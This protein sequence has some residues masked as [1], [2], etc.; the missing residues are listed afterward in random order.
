[1]PRSTSVWRTSVPQK[2][3]E[4][5]PMEVSASKSP[6]HRQL[7][8]SR[9]D[10]PSLKL[11]PQLL[12]D[13]V[14]VHQHYRVR[15]ASDKGLGRHDRLASSRKIPALLERSMST[16]R[17]TTSRSCNMYRKPTALAPA[18]QGGHGPA[19]PPP[20]VE[21][22]PP[23][24]PV[25][26][27]GSVKCCDLCPASLV[28][29]PCCGPASPLPVGSARASMERNCRPSRSPRRAAPGSRI[30]RRSVSATAGPEVG[31]MLVDD[32][33]DRALADDEVEIFGTKSRNRRRRARGPR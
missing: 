29:S 21:P 33:P 4:N 31:A 8:T 3:Q 27:L 17:V 24:V 26:Q 23:L 13:G 22:L 18:P 32:I 9:G 14:G 25:F 7:L 6:M 19:F 2:R 16:T 20:E 11:A 5:N 1:M 10:R 28:T 30:R 12:C 15:W